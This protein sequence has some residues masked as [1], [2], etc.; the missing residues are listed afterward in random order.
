MA[1]TGYVLI[2]LAMLMCTGCQEY[3][4]M[5]QKSMK[6]LCLNDEHKSSVLRVDPTIP[7]NLDDQNVS[8]PAW[9]VKREGS[10]KC[11][12][13]C[14]NPIGPVLAMLMCVG[15]QEYSNIMQKSMKNVGNSS[16]Q[17]CL[18]DEE[19]SSVS[20]VDPTIPLNLPMDDRNASCPTWSV[21]REGS[22]KCECG[23]D[24]RRNV[25]CCHNLEKLLMF[26][27]F[28]TY[29]FRLSTTDSCLATCCKA[30]FRQIICMS[31]TY[32]VW[33]L[34]PEHSPVLRFPVKTK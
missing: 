5:L 33:H 9:S 16:L 8:C 29:C 7:L 21:K 2:L 31:I 24:L 14:A 25:T 12:W 30:S 10:S 27:C 19:K 15:C 26:E 28:F 4:N 13:L 3:S 20:H 32:S 22:S 6:K 1:V 17:F 23:S 11:E 34:E 18:N